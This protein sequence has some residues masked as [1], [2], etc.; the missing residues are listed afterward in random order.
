M[1]KHWKH[2]AKSKKLVTKG[3]I[4]YYSFYMRQPQNGKS[5]EKIDQW[6]PMAEC[7]CR[8]GEWLIASF[9]L[10]DENILKK[11]KEKKE[12]KILKLD[13]GHGYTTLQSH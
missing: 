8:C 2:Y 6:L 12:E 9:F 4:L 11:R 10:D 3:Q 7:E 1:D 5:I 13:C